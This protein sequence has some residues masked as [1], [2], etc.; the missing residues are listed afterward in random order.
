MGAHTGRHSPTLKE[1]GIEVIVTTPLATNLANGCHTLWMRGRRARARLGQVCSGRTNR[2]RWGHIHG[3]II[4]CDRWS[5]LAQRRWGSVSLIERVPELNAARVAT[6][7]LAETA[8]G[9]CVDSGLD[10]RVIR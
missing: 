3:N 6:G 9:W 5:T 8:L 4:V 2:C 10:E 7:L 1:I